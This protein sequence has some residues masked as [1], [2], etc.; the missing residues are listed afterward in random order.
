MAKHLSKRLGLLLFDCD[1]EIELQTGSSISN[2][3][4][5]HGEAGFR[6]VESAILDK[7]TSRSGVLSTGG[8]SVLLDVNR[9][10]LRHRCVVVYLHSTPDEVFRRI[11]YDSLRP[12]LQVDDPLA[13]L[14]NLYIDR[15]PLYRETANIVIESGK[16]PISTLLNLI[17]SHL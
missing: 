14:K 17:V 7:L 16:F 5:L 2:Y 12:L 13:Q 10:M 1:H 4:K 8:G 11:R 3:F 6:A 15:D 9:S